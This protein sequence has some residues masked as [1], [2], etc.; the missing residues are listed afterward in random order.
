[1]APIG[2]RMKL[3]SLGVPHECDLETEGGGHGFDYYNRMAET[4]ISFLADRLDQERL[5]LA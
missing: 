2:L 5:R 1:M 3:W 4:A